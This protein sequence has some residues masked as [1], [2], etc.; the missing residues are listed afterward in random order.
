[1]RG[2]GTVCHICDATRSPPSTER[3]GASLPIIPCVRSKSVCPILVDASASSATFLIGRGRRG[4]VHFQTGDMCLKFRSHSPVRALWH[5]TKPQ[6][7]GTA[8]KAPQIRVP[9]FQ[10]HALGFEANGGLGV[11][12]RG[13][14]KIRGGSKHAGDAPRTVAY[15]SSA[16]RP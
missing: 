14:P 3:Y 6:V 8:N 12:A 13:R 7:R 15:V 1:M 10:T 4:A 5:P 2:N 16:H 11:P 9:K